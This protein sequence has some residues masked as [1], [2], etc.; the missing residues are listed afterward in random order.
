MSD[1]RLI[2]SVSILLLAVAGFF[3]WL[4]WLARNRSLWGLSLA[5]LIWLGAVI[6]YYVYLLFARPDMSEP[7]AVVSASL[8]LYEVILILAGGWLLLRSHRWGRK[9][10]H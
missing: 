4:L 3:T 5:P 10:D 7:L 2:L 6:L 8:R 9:R 1:E